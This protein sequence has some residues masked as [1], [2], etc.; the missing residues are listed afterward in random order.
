MPPPLDEES[1]AAV[2]DG[3]AALEVASMKEDVGELDSEEEDEEEEDVAE[4]AC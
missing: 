1:D 4:V 2:E 3:L